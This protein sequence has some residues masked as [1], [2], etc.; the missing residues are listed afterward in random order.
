M[1][2]TPLLGHLTE[3]KAPKGKRDTCVIFYAWLRLVESN[4]AGALNDKFW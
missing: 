4:I 2:L 1:V 3:M